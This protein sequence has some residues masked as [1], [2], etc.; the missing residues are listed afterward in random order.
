MLAATN[1]IVRVAH[2]YVLCIEYFSRTP[3]A[4]P[5]RDVGN[6]FLFKRDFGSWYMDHYPQLEIV[7]YGFLW[8]RVDSGDDLTWWLFKKN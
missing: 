8:S 1:E 5:Y 3:C 2:R 4:V 6:E 7:D